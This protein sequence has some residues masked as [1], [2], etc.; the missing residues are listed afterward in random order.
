MRQTLNLV[1]I[2]L[3]LDINLAFGQQIDQKQVDIASYFHKKDS[4]FQLNLGKQYPVFKATSLDG[5]TIGEKGLVGKVTIINF[6]FKYCEPC[7]AEM[8]ELCTLQQKFI[9]NPAFQFISFT[10]DSSEDAKESV[11][12]LKLS[13]PVYPI[14]RNECYRLNFDQGFPT[15][16]IVDKVGKIIFLKSGGSLE[17][18]EIAQ[19]IRK[20]EQ[21]IAKELNVK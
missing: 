16:I 13:F 20:L 21:I 11:E 18:E 2:L 8:D 15:T 3:V 9:E 14:S 6:W 1:L 5:Q 10:S 17:K 4:I 19:D 12:K 7:V